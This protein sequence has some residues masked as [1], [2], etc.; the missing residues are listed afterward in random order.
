MKII[1]KIFPL[2]TLLNLRHDKIVSRFHREFIS[3]KLKIN[4]RDYLTASQIHSDNMTI[5]Y[6][7]YLTTYIHC[8]PDPPYKCLLFRHHSWISGKPKGQRDFADG[9]IYTSTRGCILVV[10]CGHNGGN[11]LWF[12]VGRARLDSGSTRFPLYGKLG[13]PSIHVETSPSSVARFT[14]IK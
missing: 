10:D 3:N 14:V 7:P 4:K 9:R 13:D 11:I 1:K 2:E 5:I 6:I 12:S 8:F